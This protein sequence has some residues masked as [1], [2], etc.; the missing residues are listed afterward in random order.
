M[1]AFA[2]MIAVFY[3]RCAVFVADAAV[4]IVNIFKAAGSAKSAVLTQLVS[5][6]QRTFL[7][8]LAGKRLCAFLTVRA[9]AAG[10]APGT[11]VADVLAA[12]GAVMT[13]AL[14]AGQ[15]DKVIG[16]VRDTLVF[17]IGIK[18]A[19]AAHDAVGLALRAFIAHLALKAV[20]KHFAVEAVSAVNADQGTVFAMGWRISGVRGVASSVFKARVALPAMEVKLIFCAPLAEAAGAAYIKYAALAAVAAVIRVGIRVIEAHSAMVAEPVLL[21]N[22]LTCVA[23]RA[24]VVSLIAVA[25][26]AGVAA[27]VTAC[28]FIV[29]PMVVAAIGTIR[30]V[31]VVRVDMERHA[32]EQSYDHCKAHQ[33]AQQSLLHLFLLF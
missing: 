26:G 23:F 7:A 24:W 4:F 5:L 17:I 8:L 32:G 16:R 14:A 1:P 2:E 13:V 3:R 31:R 9:V 19:V 21:K 28:T 30:S 12:F 20:L 11:A 27:C 15:A 33:D 18:C 22:R 29:V 25:V 6:A 10:F